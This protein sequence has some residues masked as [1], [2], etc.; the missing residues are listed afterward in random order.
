MRTKARI[1]VR[2]YQVVSAD[3][4][5]EV[6]PTLWA[7][8]LEASFRNQAPRLVDLP[9]GGEGWLLGEGEPVPIGVNIS[10][11]RKYREFIER[12]LRYEGQPGTGG[13]EQRIAE[14]DLDGTDAEVL[15]STLIATML[16]RMTDSDLVCETVRAYNTWLSDYCSH[17]A[18]RLLGVGLIPF[19]GIS[20][21]LNEL[22]HISTLP[23]VRGAHLLKFP[24]G[25]EW[26]TDDD[27]P[28][29]E[30]AADLNVPLICHHNFGGETGK[31]S[32]P[33][34]GLAEKAID[35]AGSADV[36]HFIWLLGADLPLPT[37]PIVTIGQIITL[38]VLDRH[39]GLRF[40]FAETGVGW[41]AYWLEQMD[42]R[43][44]RHRH[45]AG[46][47][48]KMYPSEY[49]TQHFTF[50]FQEDH[51]GVAVR[52]LIGVDNI[53]WAS[54]FP[55]AV[56]DWPYSRETR[57][58]QFSGLTDYERRKI[59]ALN[60]LRQIGMISAEDV[61]RMAHEPLIDPTPAKVVPRGVRRM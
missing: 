37:L 42:D 24:A 2:N 51:A 59:Q 47:E 54:D 31:R 1:F 57:A 28:F 61:E 49:V 35:I 43:Y 53:C 4:H 15:F 8:Y 19:T 41:L 40:H 13:P 3:T 5:L 44:D 58:R 48:L 36:A 25:G 38:G 10:S 45:W 22:E 34:G 9:D 11:G 29:W 6:P 50:S 12:G 21:A 39:P 32:H 7:E 14:Q 27:E 46:I 33:L 52:N 56:S 20:D 60:I 18:E 26:A 55:H 17:E 16:T 23:A 30:R